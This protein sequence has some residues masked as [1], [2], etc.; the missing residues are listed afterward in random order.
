MTVVPM[1]LA[2]E[3]LGMFCL[4]IVG[5]LKC[6]SGSPHHPCTDTGIHHIVVERRNTVLSLSLQ[7]T[8]S[9]ATVPLA[10]ATVTTPLL[11]LHKM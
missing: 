9:I 3:V 2:L 6:C 7:P 1:C 4:G 8:V 5:C 10:P 11:P